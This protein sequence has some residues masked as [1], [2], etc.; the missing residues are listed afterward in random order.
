LPNDSVKTIATN[1]KALHDYFIEESYEAGIVLSGTEVKSIRQGKLNF[2]DSYA[3]V[4]GGEVILYN[5]HISPYEKGNIF[6]KDP[7]RDRKLLLNAREIRKLASYVQKDGYTLVPLKVYL[8]GQLVKVALG[9]GKGKKLYDKRD[10]EARRDAERD[11]K[12][13]IREKNK[14]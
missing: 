9:V 5:L 2:K 1:K 3:T 7:M 13:A 4:V 8:K 10:S 12:R 6:N 11:M 14:I